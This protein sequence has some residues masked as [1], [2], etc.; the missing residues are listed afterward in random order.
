[1][2]TSSFIYVDVFVFV[3]DTSNTQMKMEGAPQA[4]DHILL[5]YCLNDNTIIV[6]EE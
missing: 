5:K 3:F 1:M 2:G 6:V 4:I